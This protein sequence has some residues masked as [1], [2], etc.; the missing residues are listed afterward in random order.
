[1]RCK[2]PKPPHISYL[3]RSD[4]RLVE[5]NGQETECLESGKGVSGIEVNTFSRILIPKYDFTTGAESVF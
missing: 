2:G 1:M 5:V 4:R 3:V